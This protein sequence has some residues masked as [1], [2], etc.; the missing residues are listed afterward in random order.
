MEEIFSPKRRPEWDIRLFWRRYKTV[1][2]F[3]VQAGVVLSGDVVFS[4]SFKAIGLNDSQ[5]KMVLTM[6]E[7]MQTPKAVRELQR[8]SIR[9]F[10]SYGSTFEST[11]VTTSCG[12]DVGA[13]WPVDA[14]DYTLHVKG[15]GGKLRTASVSQKLQYGEQHGVM[16]LPNGYQPLG[17]QIDYT[18]HGGKGMGECTRCQSRDHYWAQCPHPFKKDLVFPNAP[19][20]GSVKGKGKSREGG[21]ILHM[22]EVAPDESDVPLGEYMP[23]NVGEAP[24]EEK[25]DVLAAADNDIPQCAVGDGGYSC[26][27]YIWVCCVFHSSDILGSGIVIY[28]GATS[29]VC[30]MSWLRSKVPG[31]CR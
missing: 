18:A 15:K 11:S 7:T 31:G 4:Q 13:E 24:G 20:K 22:E 19:P 28:S 1:K 3:A 2:D 17:G 25:Y 27:E 14:S 12:G 16:N 26:Q 6:S 8:L 21:S 10:A 5:G 30:G 9:L 23:G 29:T